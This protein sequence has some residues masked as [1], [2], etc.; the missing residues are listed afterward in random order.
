VARVAKQFNKPVI[1]IAGSLTSDVGVV[2]AHGLDAVYSVLF[3]ICSLE[4]A[5]AS[6]EQNV[7]LTARNVAA[8]IRIGK[9][10]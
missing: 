4:E 7:R 5:L 2:H 9:G 3:S 8:A 10:L 6:A 1:G